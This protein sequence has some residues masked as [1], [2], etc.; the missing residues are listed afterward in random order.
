MATTNKGQKKE[1][2]QETTSQTTA[3]AVLKAQDLLPENVVF[4]ELIENLKEMD[5]IEFPRVRFRQGKFFFTDD[6]EDKGTEEFEGVLLYY[7][8]QNTYWEGKYDPNNVTPPDCFSVD[9]ETGSKPRDSEGRFGKCGDCSLNVFGSGVG[10]GKACRNQMKLYVQ[11][12]GTT[13][14][15]TLFLAPTSLSNFTKSY[16]MNKITQK[17]LNYFKILTKF[18]AFKKG[19][20]AQQETFFRV[21]FEVAGVFKDEEAAQV[22]KLRDFWME[23]IKRDRARL[24]TSIGDEE[25]AP[26]ATSTKSDP[27]KNKKPEKVVDKNLR[28]VTPRQ[29]PAPVV[30]DSDEDSEM[31]VDDEEPPF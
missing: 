29:Q 14:P 6:S 19:E 16:I 17:G 20:G 23:A 10:K 22:K 24:D 7:G 11:V 13:V 12:L 5:Q 2:V 25:S 4:D 18:K 15:A 3:L 9:G 26:A 8:R 31:I 30:A 1:V 27:N 21:T 28:T